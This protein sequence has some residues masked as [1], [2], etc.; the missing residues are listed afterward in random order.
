MGSSL[1][2]NALRSDSGGGDREPASLASTRLRASVSELSDTSLNEVGNPAL[3]R[4]DFICCALHD[5]SGFSS[6]RSRDKS[7]LTWLTM[8]ETEC[9]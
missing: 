4:G 7:N 1:R 8:S 5:F 3:A 6:S 2:G 9:R